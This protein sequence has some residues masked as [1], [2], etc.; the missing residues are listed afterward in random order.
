M[1][2]GAVIAADDRR[3]AGGLAVA[4]GGGMLIGLIILVATGSSLKWVLVLTAVGCLPVMVL[5]LGSLTRTFQALLIFSLSMTLD[6]FLGYSDKFVETRPGVPVSLTAI[7]L[8]CLYGLVLIDVGH[9]G[10]PVRRRHAATVTFGL[11]LIWAG[12]SLLVAPRPGYALQALP[13]YLTSFLIYLYALRLMSSVDGIRFTSTW[14][15]LAVIV[16]GVLGCVQYLTGGFPSL[17]LLGGSETQFVQGYA[18]EQISR[19]SGLLHHP[20]TFAVFLN[21]FVP[22]LLVLAFTLTEQPLRLMCGAASALG[23]LALLLTYSR[24]GWLSFGVSLA[25]LVMVIPKKEWRPG[26][27][28]ALLTVVA[29]SLLLVAVVATPLYSRIVTRLEGDDQGAAQSRTA[30]ARMSLVLIS[31]HPFVGAGLGNYQFASPVVT[32]DR[33]VPLIEA[34]DGRPMRVH[35]LLLFTGV[36]LGIPGAAL[37]AVTIALFLVRAVSVIRNGARLSARVG[38]GLTAGLLA[39]LIHCMLEPATLADP[40]YLVLSFV[41]GCVTGLADRSASDG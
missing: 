24:G 2:P 28:M 31:E 38:L 36:E 33:G 23:T 12:L 8:L 4:A 1:M 39:I 5:G 15:A 10:A 9:S 27:G 6:I 40:S 3:N 19:V 22:L 29:L 30:L 26:L 11:F 35:N 37:L 7:L 41:G 13:G 20:N 14:I 18:N 17:A 34:G 16:S 32:D 21:G 25:V